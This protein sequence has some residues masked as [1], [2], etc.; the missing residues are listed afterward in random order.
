[1]FLGVR[2]VALASVSLPHGATC[3]LMWGQL[4]KTILC[5]AALPVV[6]LS[7]DISSCFRLGQKLFFISQQFYILAKLLLL[8]LLNF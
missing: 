2:I 1:M 7:Y 8:C 3:G 4:C 5:L 6:G